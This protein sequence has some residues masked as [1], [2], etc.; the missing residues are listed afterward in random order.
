MI[1]TTNQTHSAHSSCFARI[2]CTNAVEKRVTEELG[3][4]HIPLWSEGGGREA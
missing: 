2:L 1:I 4:A 3:L